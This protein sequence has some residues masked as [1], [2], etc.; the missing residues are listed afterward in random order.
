MHEVHLMHQVV[1]AVAEAARQA[2]GAKPSVVRLK[3][4]ALS[5]LVDHGLASI[6]SAF[7]LAS[8][9]TT[10]EGASLEVIMVPVNTFC[11]RCGSTAEAGELNP[12]CAA[13]GSED[14]ELEEVPEVEI[15]EVVVTE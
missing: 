8:I 10:A 14:I 12:R 5:H 9:G 1:K 13:C 15:H 2:E 3:I 7:E 6:K 4:S 11:R